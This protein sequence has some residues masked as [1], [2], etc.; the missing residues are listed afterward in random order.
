MMKRNKKIKDQNFKL[1]KIKKM[2][3]QYQKM[4]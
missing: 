3:R 1:A 4:S 2:K